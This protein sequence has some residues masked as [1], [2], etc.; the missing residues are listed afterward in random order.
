MSQVAR[1]VAENEFQRFADL[2]ALDVDVSKM[3]ADDA[4]SFVQQREVILAAIQ[5]GHMT[6]DEEGQPIY[7]PQ[8]DEGG[9][10]VFYEPTGATFM[11]MDGKK[12]NAD[13][14][15]LFAAMADMTKQPPIRFA[16]MKNRD[17][18]VCMAVI[19]LFLAG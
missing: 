8:A 19:T 3:D 2:M 17:M 11:A 15:K 1:E 6:I 7:A 13:M 5:R 12:K 4:K 10:I 18:K 9:P 16:K 14:S